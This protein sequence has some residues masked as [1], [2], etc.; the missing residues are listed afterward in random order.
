MKEAAVKLLLTP[1]IFA[2]SL[3]AVPIVH[4]PFDCHRPNIFCYPTFSN[5]QDLTLMGSAQQSNGAI[6]LSPDVVWTSGTVAYSNTV[7]LVQAFLMSARFSISSSGQPADGLVF[8]FQP[9]FNETG[10]L[11][12]ALSI[13]GQQGLFLAIDTFANGDY[14][15][16]PAPSVALI[17]CGVGA[18]ADP[19]HFNGCTPAMAPVPFS[20]ADG[21]VH[22]VAIGYDAGMFRV[23]IDRSNL[24]DTRLALGNF[25]AG[26]SYVEVSGV[27]GGQAQQTILRSWSLNV[28]TPE[29]TGMA[30]AGLILIA[31]GRLFPRR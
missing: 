9:N 23:S 26:P 12:G 21:S 22:S 20:L 10:P 25:L 7:D 5:T 16:P 3:V 14:G 19:N 28:D 17:G 24:I 4:P 27:T 30:V 29:P 1:L 2:F 11:G 6:M 13:F 15:D 31:I 8:R 18:G